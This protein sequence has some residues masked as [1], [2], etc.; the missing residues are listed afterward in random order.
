MDQSLFA[1]EHLQQKN[2]DQEASLIGKM[3]QL[4]I[5]HRTQ[6]DK[7]M[8]SVLEDCKIKMSDTEFELSSEAYPGNQTATAE[9]VLSLVEKLTQNANDFSAYFT[10]HLTGNDKTGQHQAD[11]IKFANLLAQA[12]STFMYNS[13]GLTR[14]GDDETKEKIMNSAKS[15]TQQ[16]KSYFH[17]LQ[18]SQ[19]NSIPFPQRPQKVQDS[20]ASFLSTLQP[21]IKSAET[22]LSQQQEKPAEDLD[23]FMDKEMKAVSAIIEQA[24]QLLATLFSTQQTAVHKS[25]LAAVQAITNAIA[26]LIICAT[27]TQAE[28]VANGKGTGSKHAFYKKNS[29]WM[30]GLISAAKAV[31]TATTFLVTEADA[32]V[33]DKEKGVEKLLVAGR[34]VQAT[35][36]QLVAASRVK[37]VPN[38]KTQQQLENAAKAVTDGMKVLI[39]ACAIDQQ[40]ES[41]QIGATS[42][43]D[44][45]RRE[46]EQQ[47]L[48]MSLERKLDDERKALGEMRRHAYHIESDYA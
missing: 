31:G 33:T 11:A 38:S 6:M 29:R 8:D 7:I 1:L 4:S 24:M 45:K 30:D 5:E 23:D 14:L 3:D 18:S 19:L 34:E 12:L 25:I 9:L 42:K 2:S 16:A 32:V 41:K 27:H 35:T 28:I 13:K 26:T 37:Q 36:A 15:I 40:R 20:N 48:I 22:L 10:R 43:H 17:Q 46:M 47:V 44:F 21:I 39:E